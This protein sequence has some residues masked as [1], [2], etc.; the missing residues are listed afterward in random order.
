MKIGVIVDNDFNSDARVI[1]E[2]KLLVDIGHEVHVLCYGYKGK[3]YPDIEGINIHR[4][5]VSMFWKKKSFFFYHLIPAFKQFWI[6]HISNFI[7]EIKPEMIHGHDLYMSKVCHK[8]IKKSALRG[9]VKMVLDLHENFPV[10]VKS[11]NWTRGTLRRLLA[12]PEKWEKLEEEYL[13]YADK[14]ITLSDDFKKVIS[15][16]FS[17]LKKENIYIIPN[18]PDIHEFNTEDKNMEPLPWTNPKAKVF[19]YFGIIAE[20]RGI[21]SAIEAFENLIQQGENLN[22]L[23]IGP[24]D[25]ADKSLFNAK[26]KHHIQSG[27][28]IYIP[29]IQLAE[30]TNYMK[31]G[32]IGLAPFVKNDQHDSGIANKIFQYMYGSLPIIASNCKPQQD[33]IEKEQIGAIFS[34]QAELTELMKL[35]AKSTN[36]DEIGSKAKEVLL[37]KYNMTHYRDT[38]N[39]IFSN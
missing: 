38:M 11:Y 30:L 6:R 20:R 25:K 32:D 2:A 17:F 14:I 9:K 1:K 4:C 27:R 15:G 34:N 22:M 39:N 35:Y 21:F 18:V 16:K 5:W 13:S 26:T 33:L 10:A 19:F 7:N 28:L 31:L 8:G 37:E 3:T 36:L 24:V 29:W 23:L 12:Q